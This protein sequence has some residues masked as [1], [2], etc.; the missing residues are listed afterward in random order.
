MGSYH[1][2]ESV[3][4]SP[5]DLTSKTFL[6]HVCFVRD[7]LLI[8]NMTREYNVNTNLLLRS[9]DLLFVFSPKEDVS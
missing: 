7:T 6:M 8:M 1:R 3:S 5:F 9:D 2:P 4:L